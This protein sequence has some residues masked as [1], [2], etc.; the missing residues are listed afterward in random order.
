MRVCDVLGYLAAGMTIDEL[1]D[2][3]PY[4]ER[5]DIFAA[6]DFAADLTEDTKLDNFPYPRQEYVG[7]KDSNSRLRLLCH[8]YGAQHHR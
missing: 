6:L 8:A 4:L 5:D 3:F 1:L 2:D 7:P